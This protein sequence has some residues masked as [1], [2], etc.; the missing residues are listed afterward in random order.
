MDRDTFKKYHEEEHR[1]G[2]WDRVPNLMTIII[3]IIIGWMF[4]NSLPRPKAIKDG[5]CAM[6]CGNDQRPNGGKSTQN[7]DEDKSDKTG[8]SVY[9]YYSSEK[10]DS[11]EII[12]E[13]LWSKLW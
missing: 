12:N 7:I 3:L 10:L 2:I 11:K 8:G 9:N 5:V 4:Y 13:S 1:R 6:I